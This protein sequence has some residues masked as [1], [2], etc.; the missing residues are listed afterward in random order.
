MSRLFEKYVGGDSFVE[1]ENALEAVFASLDDTF[2]NNYGVNMRYYQ[3]YITNGANPE[4]RYVVN[5]SK[6]K[7]GNLKDAME[8]LGKRRDR[9]DNDEVYNA[10]AKMLLYVFT[11]GKDTIAFL[12]EVKAQGGQVEL[13]LETDEKPR[14]SVYGS[15]FLIP[16][17][18]TS[19]QMLDI[20]GDMDL[21]IKT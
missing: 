1:D 10:T 15:R 21:L 19:T 20:T 11:Q 18:T 13:S 17:R 7:V 8:T 16:G 3:L 12:K 4:E 5:I 9:F 2:D 6:V 14:F